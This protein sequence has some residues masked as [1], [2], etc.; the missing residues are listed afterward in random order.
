MKYFTIL[1]NLEYSSL[2]IQLIKEW[3]KQVEF[4]FNHFLNQ[5]PCGEVLA[6]LFEPSNVLRQGLRPH[7]P[8]SVQWGT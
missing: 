4:F 8:Q 7:P 6:L 5:N 1:N 2:L 3:E